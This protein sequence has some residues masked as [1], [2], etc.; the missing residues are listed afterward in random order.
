MTPIALQERGRERGVSSVT[1]NE[2]LGRN[3]PDLHSDKGRLEGQDVGDH[4]DQATVVQ[5][6]S[7]VAPKHTFD[8][9]KLAGD[10]RG[11]VQPGV[12]KGERW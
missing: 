5:R 12:S 2:Q 1:P 11:A 7:I 8:D 10:T 4:E 6:P 9:N 3:V